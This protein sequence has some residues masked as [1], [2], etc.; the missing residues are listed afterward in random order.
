M[1]KN[2]PGKRVSLPLAINF[3]RIKLTPLPK[4]IARA[5]SDCLNSDRASL[6]KQRLRLSD[7][8]SVLL[9]YINV[10]IITPEVME[11]QMQIRSILRFSWSIL[12]KCFHLRTSYRK[13]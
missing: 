9:T 10:Y 13:T 5:N 6:R 7:R 4:L 2:C 1:K 11:F 8:N 3:M 12:V